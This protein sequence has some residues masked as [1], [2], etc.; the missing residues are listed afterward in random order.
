MTIPAVFNIPAALNIPVTLNFTHCMQHTCGIEHTC[1][2]KHKQS[3]DGD[4]AK[5]DGLNHIRCWYLM[6]SEWT[7]YH[8]T[9]W[10]D[11]FAVLLTTETST[12]TIMVIQYFMST[13]NYFVFLC[14]SIYRFYLKSM[15]ELYLYKT[16][17]RLMVWDI[18]C[19][20]H[21]QCYTRIIRVQLQINLYSYL[22]KN[23][24]STAK[25]IS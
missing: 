18:T 22:M 24:S 4:R 12:E 7:M 17:I 21:C 25:Y 9:Q 14:R 16:C 8:A 3:Q 15:M 23:Y 10:Y 1:S 20:I 13:Y 19:F 11:L 2:S 5:W 6:L